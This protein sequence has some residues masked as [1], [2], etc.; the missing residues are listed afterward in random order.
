MRRIHTKHPAVAL[1]V[2]LLSLALAL[3]PALANG[4]EPGDNIQADGSTQAL[5]NEDGA[6]ALV[7]TATTADI[8]KYGNI[9]LS[10][11]HEDL[12]AA[13]EYGD[14]VSVSFV[15][16]T[17]DVPFVSTFSDVDAGEAALVSV[18]GY[19]PG[20]AINRGDF[21]T[22]YG[23]ATKVT[24]DDGTIAWKYAKGVSGPVSFA[25]TLK[26]KGGYRDEWLLRHL[27]Y[28]DE[29]SD[30]AQLSDE[31]F[32]NFRAVTTTGMGAG[33]LYRSSSPIRPL[34][35]RNAYADAAFRAHGVTRA[36]DL[37]DDEATARSYE[38]YGKTRFAGIEHVALN[39]D[40]SFE[41]DDFRAKLAE[42]LRF[43]ARA[44]GTYALFCNE[45]IDRAGFVS[46]VVEC[47]MGAS[48]DEVVEDFM[49]SYRNY[50]GVV[51]GDVRYDL[52]VQGLLARPL[53]A[54]LGVSDLASA[55]LAAAAEG[56]VRGL[57]LGEQEVAALKRNLSGRTQT[58]TVTFDT[59]GRGSAPAAQSVY[60]GE[61]AARP[62]D[63]VASGYAFVGWYTEREG[64][65]S[66]DFSSAITRDL[67]LY[68]RWEAAR[69]P[70][71]QKPTR[72][73]PSEKSWAKA[74]VVTS[75][76]S[77]TGA[78]TLPSTADT[79]G[80]PLAAAAL[81]ALAVGIGTC[82]ALV[83]RRSRE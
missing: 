63:P 22:T 35:R 34:H 11:S 50:Y 67:T 74:T 57:G 47:L 42:G 7:A 32:A 3:T 81:A 61:T 54:A 56:Y 37:A 59:D 14:I 43:I 31:E 18:V 77:P 70:E 80:S 17:I 28:T 65:E 16:T 48:Y 76:K 44:P 2:A 46:A 40:V 45:G 72:P 8:S 53:S 68:A 6:A 30:Y 19:Q 29:R 39:M 4:S 71:P 83:R 66:F 75:T 1:S 9:G 51:P 24:N 69:V 62:T 33:V 21:A 12:V 25:V 23:I 10:L 5:A 26:E 38:G 52:I 36:V 79:T 82:S 64:G 78:A 20:L 60:V 13:F 15:G 55:D 73:M 27:H 58:Y 41:G 49:T